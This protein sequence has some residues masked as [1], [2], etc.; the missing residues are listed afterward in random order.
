MVGT[1]SFGT[2]R[3]GMNVKTGEL[4]AVKQVPLMDDGTSNTQVE[5]LMREIEI[6]STLRHHNIVRYLGTGREE[7]TLNIYL[8]FV[9]GGS[10]QSLLT[11]MGPFPE[12]VIAMYTKQILYG[13]EY[14]HSN[15]IIHRGI[16]FYFSSTSSHSHI[17]HC[18]RYQGWKYSRLK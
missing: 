8:E 17:A 7:N 16:L 3:M 6:L 1:G 9:T 4:I 2:V 10:I 14:L 18:Y 11:K 5:S 15:N 12:E 13:L